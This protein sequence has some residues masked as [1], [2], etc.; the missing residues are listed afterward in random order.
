[1]LLYRI[2]RA[3][4]LRMATGEVVVDVHLGTPTTNTRCFWRDCSR[5]ATITGF[6]LPSEAED[7]SGMLSVLSRL[8]L[9]TALKKL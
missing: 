7:Q 3:L 9:T 8:D 6:R 1:M 4:V 5:K 2:S